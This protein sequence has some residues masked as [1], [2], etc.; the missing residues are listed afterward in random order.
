MKLLAN[1]LLFLLRVKFYLRK[2][3]I[4][5]RRADLVLD[6]G[7]G[8][9]PHPRA[10]ILLDLYTKDIHRPFCLKTDNRPFII[11]NAGA[12]PFKDKAIDFIICSQV[13]EHVDHPKE[14]LDEMCRVAR[15]GYIETPSEIM[16]KIC[17]MP[18]HKWFV[19][20]QGNKII[21]KRKPRPFYDEELALCFFKLWHSKD[22]YHRIWIYTLKEGMIRYFWHNKIDYE[23]Q[24][25]PQHEINNDEFSVAC[26]Q[27]M[28]IPVLQDKGIRVSIK[29]LIKYYYELT[30]SKKNKWKK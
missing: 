4:G 5:Y 6:V 15:R 21:F 22:A 12:L 17:D 1:I 24:D 13:L 11:A 3:N 8:N 26:R 28:D 23:I 10:D 19:K 16:Q 29:K 20:Q 14:A 30:T 25:L 18:M 7:S 2:F 27:N 9:D